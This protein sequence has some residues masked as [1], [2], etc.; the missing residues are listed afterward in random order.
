MLLLN[1]LD[2]EELRAVIDAAEGHLQNM[3]ESDEKEPLYD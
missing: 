3:D 2:A 1:D